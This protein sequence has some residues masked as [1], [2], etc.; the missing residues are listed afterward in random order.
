LFRLAGHEQADRIF[1]RLGEAGI[2]VRPFPDRPKWLRFGIP[3]RE[4]DWR[5][6]AQALVA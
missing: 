4:E 5:R 2:L 6:L 1:E 3:G